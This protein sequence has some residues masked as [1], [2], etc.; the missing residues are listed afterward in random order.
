VH[1]GDTLSAIASY[2]G[3]TVEAIV[4]AS[5]LSDPGLLRAGQELLV[6][7]APPATTTPP[8]AAPAPT[9]LPPGG[10]PI[11]VDQPPAG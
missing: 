10:E 11:V 7:V 3:T 1:P 9:P 5:R 8:E 4:K 2:Y 6:P